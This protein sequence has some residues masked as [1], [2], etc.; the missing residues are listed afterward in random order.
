VQQEMVADD[1]SERVLRWAVA[2]LGI[3]G[4]AD[5]F[6]RDLVL[7]RVPSTMSPPDTAIAGRVVL[8]RR[9]RR[10]PAGP[11]ASSSFDTLRAAVRPGSVV[12]VAMD[13][14]IG[15]AFGS[16]LA[17]HTACL[18]AQALIADGPARDVSRISRVPLA[19]GWTGTD[20]RR[21]SGAV[22]HEVTTADLFGRKWATGDWYVADADG[23]LRLPSAQ[24]EE[25]ASALLDIH[26]DQP[27]F[28]ALVGLSTPAG[29]AAPGGA[30]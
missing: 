3:A 15:A 16:N 24:G 17:L 21:P 26:A 20:A 12:L 5:E 7:D 28:A 27:E 9:T 2:E 14:A 22:M 25:I 4:I 8:M 23:A 30:R 11:A 13:P 19:C 18:G 6:G 29:V 1:R 10:S